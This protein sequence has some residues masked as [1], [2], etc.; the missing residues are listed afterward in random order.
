MIFTPD[1]LLQLVAQHAAAQR[2]PMPVDQA[3]MKEVVAEAAQFAAG[4]PDDEPAASTTS[5]RAARACSGTSGRRSSTI[6]WS[7]RP[8]LLAFASTPARSTSWSSG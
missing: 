5:A 8:R 2:I 7:L 1:A 3:M 6:S 4:H